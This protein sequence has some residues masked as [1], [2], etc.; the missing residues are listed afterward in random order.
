MVMFIKGVIRVN[1]VATPNPH[2]L[3]YLPLQGSDHITN[4]VL[5][6][7]LVQSHSLDLSFLYFC[8][9]AACS[10][11]LNV[12]FSFSP[13]VNKRVSSCDVCIVLGIGDTL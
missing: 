3:S 4:F 6:V 10:Q 8:L 9:V 1:L 12:D 5:V 7:K 11:V 2:V 13:L